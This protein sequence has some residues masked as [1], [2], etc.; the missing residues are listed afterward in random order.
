MWCGVKKSGWGKPAKMD[1]VPVQHIEI[2]DG[3]AC[4]LSKGRRLKAKL[5]AAM[6]V[7]A[8]A[9]IEETME[10]YDLTYAEVHAALTYYYDNQEAIET[11]FKDAETYVREMGTSLDE[12][13]VRLQARQKQ[14]TEE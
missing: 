6:V 2:I 11:S 3:K 9:S 7:K 1:T 8:G 12:L 4:I 10:Y 5:I 14:Q 13:I